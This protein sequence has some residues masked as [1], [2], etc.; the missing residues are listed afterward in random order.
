VTHFP[1]ETL[2]APA[3]STGFLEKLARQLDNQENP[4]EAQ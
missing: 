2:P 4:E 1:C 3:I